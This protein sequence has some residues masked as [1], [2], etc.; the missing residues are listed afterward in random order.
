MGSKSSAMPALCIFLIS[1][2][3]FPA[4]YF[5]NTAQ[6]LHGEV[7][8]L[9]SGIVSLAAICILTYF[10]LSSFKQPKDWLFY[11]KTIWRV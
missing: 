7:G 1:L 10:A 3:G 8:L 9:V 2:L 5:I 6:T 11:G 4:A